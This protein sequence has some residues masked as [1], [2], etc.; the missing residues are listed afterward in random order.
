MVSTRILP[1]GRPG[2]RSLPV[3]L[4]VPRSLPVPAHGAPCGR[5]RA[6]L[7][8]RGLCSPGASPAGRASGQGRQRRG[9]G[10]RPRDVPPPARTDL[11]G[12]LG[13]PQREGGTVAATAPSPAAAGSPLAG[14]RVQGARAAERC[15]EQLAAV[16]ERK[17]AGLLTVP[18]P[19][20]GLQEGASLNTLEG[21]E[22]W[23]ERER[24]AG[25]A[26]G[27][28]RVCLSSSNEVQSRCHPLISWPSMS[29]RT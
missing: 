14:L 9:P 22:L 12:D 24:S 6:R 8:R 1:S 2:S 10:Q 29:I 4:A 18:P 28:N 26:A 15:L 20:P 17:E 27:H 3:Q 7:L 21:C 13:K 25:G 23:R 16:P 11:W 19:S 5:R